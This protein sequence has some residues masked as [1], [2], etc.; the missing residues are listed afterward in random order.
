[1]NIGKN[2]AYEAFFE[3]SIARPKNWGDRVV[4][5]F[6]D[7]FRRYAKGAHQVLL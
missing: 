4:K 7:C 5:R 2:S 1:M 6:R 3:T